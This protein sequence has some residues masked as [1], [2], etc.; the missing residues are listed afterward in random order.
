MHLCR[1]LR[2]YQLNSKKLNIIL[3]VLY[4]TAYLYVRIILSA[5][6]RLDGAPNTPITI[7]HY[8]MLCAIWY[9]GIILKT[10]KTPMEE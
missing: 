1:N 2:I 3:M 9:Q 8:A 10:L 5:M 6:V 4:S 7:I